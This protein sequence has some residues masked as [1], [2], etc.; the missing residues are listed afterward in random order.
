MSTPV[1]PD[2]FKAYDIRG[3]YPDQIDESIARD[4]GR[5]FIGYLGAR[6]IAVPKCLCR[7]SV[8]SRT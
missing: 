3:T 6:R 2:I 5:G 8:K 4:I 7:R 1:N